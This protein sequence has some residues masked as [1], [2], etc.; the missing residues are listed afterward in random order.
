MW[1][2]LSLCRSPPAWTSLPLIHPMLWPMLSSRGRY[3]AISTKRKTER[4]NGGLVLFGLNILVLIVPNGH[5]FA[6][7][8]P[9]IRSARRT[10]RHSIVVFRILHREERTHFVKKQQAADRVSPAPDEDSTVNRGALAEVNPTAISEHI[11]TANNGADDAEQRE[12]IPRQREF[13][14]V[15]GGGC[16]SRS[17]GNRRCL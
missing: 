2:F 16:D 6:C 1:F 14:G 10:F 12:E 17:H 11:S 9:S 15:F 7:Q 13:K 5:I 8:A 3:N 4:K